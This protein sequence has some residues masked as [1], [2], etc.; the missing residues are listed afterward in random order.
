MKKEYVLEGLSCAHCA[1]K[2][3]EKIG[4]IKE[5]SEVN[6]NFTTQTLSF[7][8]EAVDEGLIKKLQ[9]EINRIESGVT[10]TLK[11]RKPH[12]HDHNHGISSGKKLWIRLGI[13][14][15]FFMAALLLEVD[16]IVELAIYLTAYFIIGGEVLLRA[17]KN[18][19]RGKVFDENF[20]MAV[21]TIGA[22]AIGE[23]PEGVTV[24]L[25]YN[26][27]EGFQDMA[28]ERSRANIATL[29]DI[30]PDVAWVKEAGVLKQVSAEDIA[31]GSSIWVKA[32]ERIPLDGKVLTGHSMLDTS[33]LTGESVPR[34]V[35][36]GDGVLSGSVNTN[37]LL[38]IKVEK[39]FEDSTVA[40]I[41]KLVENASSKK[42]E[43]EKF[44][45]KFAKYYTP[46]VVYLAL[47][48]AII[49]PLVISGATFS[50][51]IN[52][53]LVFLVVSCPCALV[54]SIPLGFFGGIGGASK[55]GILIKGGNYLE[56]LNSVD[57]IVFDKTGTL[58]KGVFKVI[59]IKSVNNTKD[60]LLE[61]AAY[62]E[63]H[64]NHPIAK[65]IVKAYSK[66]INLDRLGNY[67][68]V[69]GKGIKV[70]FDD[71]VVYAGNSIFMKDNHISIIEPEV[72]GTAVHIAIGKVYL[73]HIIIS[74]E[75]KEDSKTALAN[76]RE[77]GIKKLIMLTG[78]HHKVATYIGNE[79]GISEI[80]SELLPHNKVEVLED[81]LS[82]NSTGKTIFVGDGINDAPVLARADIGVAMGGIGSDAAIEAA[83][84]VLMTDELSKL[85]D[86]IKIAKRTKVIVWQNI[87]FAMGTK[88][89]VLILGAV[90]IATMWAAV[91][92]DVGVALIAIINAM[93]IIRKPLKN[94]DRSTI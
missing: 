47:A 55:H 5:F 26:I 48:L 23:F 8:T 82:K 72:F 52:R 62:A 30:R 91:F 88:G 74:D 31:V 18:I 27:G 45:T 76:L 14:L 87:V 77:M 41:L 61:V 34:G 92:A 85:V 10:V 19:L 35:G 80:Y 70:T 12:T 67:E 7:D 24:M 15:V 83:D 4:G 13:G 28:L 44:I 25:F 20:L 71:E 84:I 94:N 49:P 16:F 93:R 89:V 63:A 57:T 75:I 22:F 50:E 53:A 39:V 46:V 43:I 66:A 3:E 79:V 78:D 37:S 1:T 56:A 68:E 90:G 73:G 21:A 86:S 17:G 36:V 69:A 11:N 54:I 6:L 51:W 32:G 40:K 59:N 2:I 38:E 64:S 29:M 81:I 9:K 42:A 60:A 58:T 65:S 33:A